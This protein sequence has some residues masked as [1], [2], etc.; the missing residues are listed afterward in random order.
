MKKTITTSVR[1][2]DFD[3]DDCVDMIA[4][5]RTRGLIPEAWSIGGWYAI[6]LNMD[7]QSS[8]VP[9]DGELLGVPLHRDITA[10]NHAQLICGVRSLNSL[11][12]QWAACNAVAMSKL[13]SGDAEVWELRRDVVASMIEEA[14][15]DAQ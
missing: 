2:Q 7:V 5:A 1:A 9:I 8:G 14:I 6:S 3:I 12:E 13:R 10:S 4:E 15:A 11:L